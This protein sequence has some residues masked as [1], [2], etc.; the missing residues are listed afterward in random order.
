MDT[1]LQQVLANG[2]DAISRIYADDNLHQRY[3][4]ELDKLPRFQQPETYPVRIVYIGL[5]ESQYQDAEGEQQLVMYVWDEAQSCG[6]WWRGSLSQNYKRS[7]KQET[8]AA[9]TMRQLAK[10]GW[11]GGEDWGGLILAKIGSQTEAWVTSRESNGRTYLGVAA[12][13]ARAVS[14]PVK[15]SLP[16]FQPA[17]NQPPA[18]TPPAQQPQQ[19]QQQPQQPFQQP[20]QSQPQTQPQQFQPQPQQPQRFSPP[21]L[22]A[23]P[24]QQQYQSPAFPPSPNNFA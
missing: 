2:P 13:G 3:K 12:I 22:A 19:F 23:Q 21:P 9:G 18:F 11:T 14:A 10:I 6:G 5:E 15:I 20:Q 8:Y 24:G 4:N 1:W 7:G 17:S 16:K